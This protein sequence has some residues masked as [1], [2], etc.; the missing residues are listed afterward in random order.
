M[1][2]IYGVS[3][4][5]SMTVKSEYLNDYTHIGIWLYSNGRYG[6]ATMSNS[7]V[8]YTNLQVEIGS[9]VTTYE[10]YTTVSPKDIVLTNSRKTVCP[11]II[12]TDD[13]EITMGNGVYNLS[14]GTHKVLNIQLFEGDTS[15]SLVGTGAVSF[16]YQ[17]GDL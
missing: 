17:E 4:S 9:R 12:C 14:A 16:N 2:N 15:M 8:E 10:P 3:G 11:T 1:K 7:V 6:D 5:D 13:I